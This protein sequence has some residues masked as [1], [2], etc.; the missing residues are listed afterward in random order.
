[1]KLM[2]LTARALKFVT[3][4]IVVGLA[5]CAKEPPVQPVTVKGDSFCRI[6]KKIT[7]STLDTADTRAQVRRHNAKHD[8]VC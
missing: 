6:S 4:L 8:K 1:M 5:G 2:A 3:P 7:W